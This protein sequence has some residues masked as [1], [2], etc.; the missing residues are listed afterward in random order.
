MR[1]AVT[2]AWVC[3][4]HIDPAFAQSFTPQ[5]RARA[6]ELFKQGNEAFRTGDVADARHRYLLAWRLVPSFDIACNLGRAEAELELWPQAGSHL[7]YCLE[8][9]AATNKPEY[10]EAERKFRELYEVVQLR[11]IS[12]LARQG[13]CDEAK[14]T[15]GVSD[16]LS[17]S[18]GV[19][20]AIAECDAGRGRLVEALAQY[21]RVLELV[22]R[23][24]AQEAAILD[25]VRIARES[26]R[27][28]IPAVTV[29]LESSTPVTR[30]EVDGK[31]TSVLALRNRVVL[32]PGRH[33]LLIARSG[34]APY[35]VPF[36][37]AEGQHLI[38]RPELSATVEALVP[39]SAS[40]GASEP[41]ADST[42][43]SRTLVLV[44]EAALSVVGLA[45]GTGFLVAHTAALDRARSTQT[46]IAQATPSKGACVEPTAELAPP[47]DQLEQ[48]G[49]DV[50]RYA[51]L[52]TVG[53][54]VAGAGAAGAL[55]T[56]WFWPSGH[57]PSGGSE[58]ST[59]VGSVRY[60]GV[61]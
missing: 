18:P 31:R 25:R 57:G 10:R 9:Y 61:F 41:A 54:A 45:V 53:F 39:K 44:G 4:G 50:R 46:E 29:T 13:R 27:R 14:R 1:V 17:G 12:S 58:R 5:D 37:L 51:D 35:E 6:T 32:N 60:Q 59:A 15:L 40:T 26:I 56:F 49:S 3:L 48:A 21:D 24:R 28:R 8:H 43:P 19:L 33:R 2:V 22:D 42:I 55:L 11:E 16:T 52:A 36:E 47:C 30:A 38:L 23:S 34:Q 20:S 7:R